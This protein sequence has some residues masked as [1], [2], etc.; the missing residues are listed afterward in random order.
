MFALTSK[1]KEQGQKVKP[2]LPLIHIRECSTFI[3]MTLQLSNRT[4]NI[5]LSH[6]CY[7]RTR[8][9]VN[10]KEARYSIASIDVTGL[11]LIGIKSNWQGRKE[12]SIIICHVQHK[13]PSKWT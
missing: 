9:L 2:A 10:Y 3:A 12:L 1:E 6:F 4:L 8:F 7:F 5:M 13:V 11:P